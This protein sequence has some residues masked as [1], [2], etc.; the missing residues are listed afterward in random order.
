MISK[1]NA[2]NAIK[3]LKILTK[4]AT[5]INTLKLDKIFS[6]CEQKSLNA[7]RC[8]IKSQEQL[9]QFSLVGGKFPIEFYGIISALESQKNSLQ[10]VTIENCAC[11]TVFKTL[12]NCKN[13]EILRLRHCDNVEILEVSL[14]TFEI[15]SC[16]INA[17]NIVQILQKSG[18]FLQR[19]KLG[20]VGEETLL[21]ETIK[22]FCPNITYLGLSF[23]KFSSQLLELIG[24]LQKL[25]FL[26]LWGMSSIPEELNMRIIQFAKT[27]PLTL[28]YLD[29][30]DFWLFK[31][32]I[33]ILLNHC[34]VPL[35]KLIINQL[36]KENVKALIEFCIR[37][38][39][40]QYVNLDRFQ[41]LDDNIRKEI[42]VYVTLVPYEQIVVNC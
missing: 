15:T 24:N 39:T 19:L 28:Q 8:I 5:K 11:S 29:L 38:K 12:M 1:F 40:L 30:E 27:L 34:N 37:N 2:E 4:N 16:T 3:L 7:L 10:E 42:E 17:S 25:Q 36:D 21:L 41:R 31:S 32:N 9:R 35:K 13:L 18:T 6:D 22:S 23:F 14:K 20:P 26:T 33:D